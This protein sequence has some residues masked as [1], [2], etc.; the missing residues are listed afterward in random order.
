MRVPEKVVQRHI[1]QLFRSLGGYAWELG[2]RRGRRDYDKGTRQT[3]G[4]PDLIGFLPPRQTPRWVLLFVEA[5]AQGGRLR[6]EQAK[7]RELCLAADVAHLVGDLD[8]VIAWCVE[9]EY[10]RR[11]HVAHYRLAAALQEPSCSR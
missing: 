4:V 1:V 3:P 5:K 7:F 11:D 2:T 10:L 9:H 8:V 6:P